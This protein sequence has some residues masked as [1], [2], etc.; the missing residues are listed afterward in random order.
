MRDWRFYTALGASVLAMVG[1]F[2]VLIVFTPCSS[3]SPAPVSVTRF[4]LIRTATLVRAGQGSGSGMLFSRGNQCFILTA[5]HVVED[6]DGQFQAVIPLSCDG[7]IVD[8]GTYN[9]ECVLYSPSDEYDT[10]VLRVLYTS[11]CDRAA[12]LVL[13]LDLPVGTDLQHVGSF[14]GDDGITSYSRG[15]LAFVG[16]N[17]NGQ[18]FD[19]MTAAAYP[20]SS[21]GGVYT[22]DGRYAGMLVRGYDSSFTLF[23][24]A[25]ELL[26]WAKQAD[27]RWVFDPA[28]AVP[29]LKVIEFSAPEEEYP[30]YPDMP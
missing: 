1:L 22:L 28:L 15:I 7:R 17:H 20:G 10:A 3:N 13:A 6:T 12:P 5:G 30:Y 27:C 14:L 19:Q 26:K 29:E 11:L 21:G 18:V 2:I 23:T 4:D 16:R 8:Y 24:P 9:T 25:R